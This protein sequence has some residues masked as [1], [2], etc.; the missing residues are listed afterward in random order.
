MLPFRVTDNPELNYKSFFHYSTNLALRD[1][2][3]RK[4]KFTSKFGIYLGTIFTVKM[5]VIFC[6][7][8]Q[9]N[10]LW[11]LLMVLLGNYLHIIKINAF[12]VYDSVIFSNLQSCIIITIIQFYLF[13]F[14]GCSF[15]FLMFIF[16]L[17]YFTILYWFC[18]TLT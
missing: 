3:Q 9:M 6:V 12:L 11:V 1:K 8:Y 13:I 5:V 18:H 2:R 7:I 10:F 17:F 4:G 14:W 16:T 15:F